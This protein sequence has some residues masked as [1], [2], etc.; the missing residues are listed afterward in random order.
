[1]ELEAK[2]GSVLDEEWGDEETGSLCRQRPYDPDFVLFF[3]P[4]FF[5]S[6]SC[7]HF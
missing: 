3:L 7:P 5:T 4:C 2:E 6:F 1:M